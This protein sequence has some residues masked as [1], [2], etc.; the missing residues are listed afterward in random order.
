MV[1]GDPTKPPKK[2]SRFFRLLQRH[3]DQSSGMAFQ[4]GAAAYRMRG[5][6]RTAESLESLADSSRNS[7]GDQDDVPRY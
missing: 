2:R 1:F 3:A 7:R 4:E 6:H 5:D